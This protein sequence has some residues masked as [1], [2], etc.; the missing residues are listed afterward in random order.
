MMGG[1]PAA[2]LV[3][4]GLMSGFFLVAVVRPSSAGQWFEA[5]PGQ[6]LQLA[7]WAHPIGPA[8]PAFQSIDVGLAG[9][10]LVYVTKVEAGSSATIA[11]G[12]C[13]SHW[14]EPGK[15][16]VDLLVEGKQSVTVDLIAD[17]GGQNHPF[18]VLLEAVDSDK[19]GRASC[20]ESV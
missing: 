16:L 8:S 9:N 11:A 10:P 2:W 19:I 13:E 20:R 18:V 12:F 1:A 6:T 15:R 3:W 7:G 5:S 17:G 14:S 4:I